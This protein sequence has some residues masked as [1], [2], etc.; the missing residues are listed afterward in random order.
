M[1]PLTWSGKWK[2]ARRACL[3]FSPLGQ[4]QP[5]GPSSCCDAMD[6]SFIDWV[7]K[8]LQQ[9]LP[10][11]A[12]QLRMAHPARRVVLDTPA[13]A[14]PSA[15]LVLFFPLA[16]EWNL[17][18]IERQAHNP[19]DK[20]K[21]QISF[22]GGRYDATDESLAHTALREA[23]EEIGVPAEAVRLL[24]RLTELYIPVSNYAVSPFVGM[25]PYTPTFVPQATEVRTIL[26]MSWQYF[27]EARPGTTT[28]TLGEKLRLN[29]IPYFDLHGRILWGATAMMLSELLEALR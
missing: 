11:A 13:D 24:G 14:V 5:P 15:V 16:T 27:Q 3:N 28:I 18:F 4:T 9:P 12:A 22:P 29:D 25:L 21:G 6:F 26:P 8:R 17:V 23:E 2:Q 1:R 19:N 20:H 7:E 10:G